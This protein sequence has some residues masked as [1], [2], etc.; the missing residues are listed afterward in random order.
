MQ[1]ILRPVSDARLSEI[2]VTESR[3]AIGRNEEH[4]AAYER[5]IVA[6][7]SRRHAR[8]FERDGVAYIADLHSSNGTTVNGEIVEG[9][10]VELRLNDEVQFGGL[11]YRVEYLD[12]ADAAGDADAPTVDADGRQRVQP[13]AAQQHTVVPQKLF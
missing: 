4:F 3:F 6:K 10:P 8:I 11:R 9:E 13:V 12:G 5:S 1:L 2:I 7:L